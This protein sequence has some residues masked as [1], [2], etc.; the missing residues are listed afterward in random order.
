MRINVWGQFALRLKA[1]EQYYSI[2]D[3][4]ISLS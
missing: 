4:Q 3:L 1:G 2:R